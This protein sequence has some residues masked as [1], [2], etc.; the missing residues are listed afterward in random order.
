M[1]DNGFYY[2]K[3]VKNSKVIKFSTKTQ[4]KEQAE[5]IYKKFLDVL[6]ERNIAAAVY[7]NSGNF[8]IAFKDVKKLNTSVSMRDFFR[9]Y[10]ET[11]KAKG[12]AKGVIASKEGFFR[13]LPPI[14]A[15]WDELTQMNIMKIVQGLKVSDDHKREFIKQL[16]AFLNFAIKR[17]VYSQDYYNRLEFPIFKGKAKELIIT[18]DDFKRIMDATRPDPDFHFYLQTLYYTVSRPAE[19]TTLKLL[20]FD[21]PGAKL[22]VY[23]NKVKKTKTV[24]LPPEYMAMLSKYIDEQKIKN[25]LFIGQTDTHEHYSKK[26][27]KLKKRLGLNRAYTLYTIR[28]TAIT[29]LL[30]KTNDIEFVSRQAGNNPETAVKHYVNRNDDH[31]RELIRK[32]YQ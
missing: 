18:D 17:G 4:D 30:N 8:D 24:Y 10:I 21:L 20:D 22:R 9:E 3:V 32:A 23:Q 7:G 5:A 27:M 12:F 16:K 2:I 1:H 26:F 15:N 13:K 29:N 28:H 11:C 6:A 31:N 19:V 14:I 25:N